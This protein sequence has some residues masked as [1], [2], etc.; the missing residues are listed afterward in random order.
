MYIE[1]DQTYTVFI[2]VKKIL[3]LLLNRTGSILQWVYDGKTKI[4][5]Y[6]QKYR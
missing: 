6:I 5:K 4:Y 3:E 2:M 1:P